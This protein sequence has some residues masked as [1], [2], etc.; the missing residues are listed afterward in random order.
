MSPD[1][2]LAQGEEF[3]AEAEVHLREY[4]YVILKH[5]W[6]I[7]AVAVTVVAVSAIGS[8]LQTPQYKATALIQV[9][10]GKINLVQEVMVEDIRA[11]YR[12]FYG[13]QQRVLKSRT[14][15][16][17]AMDHLRIWQH[18]LFE[19]DA[20][21]ESPEEARQKQID[22][23]V[24]MVEVSPVRNTQLVEVS[25]MTPDPALSARMANA[26]VGQYIAFN[27]EAES[28]LA[29]NTASF[30]REQIQKLQREIQEKEKLLQEYS[31]R[32]DIVMMDEKENIIVQQL[33]DLNRQ[34]SEVHAE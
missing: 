20:G 11:G 24:E 4:W 17:R 19:V 7:G 16:R 25:L 29:R 6:L 34:L 31:Q 21:E 10:R 12:E 27:A 13:T 3:Y 33:G 15:A 30:I 22:E 26:L 23:F 8:F 2:Q 1:R 18:P 5:R 14:L 9:D 28:G 32:E